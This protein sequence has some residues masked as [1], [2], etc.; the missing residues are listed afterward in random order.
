MGCCFPRKL[1]QDNGH[2]KNRKCGRV[3][4]KNFQNGKNAATLPAVLVVLSERQEVL[5]SVF[6]KLDILHFNITYHRTGIYFHQN[7]KLFEKLLTGI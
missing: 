5:S 1:S 7:E 6:V 4:P 2:Q 3:H